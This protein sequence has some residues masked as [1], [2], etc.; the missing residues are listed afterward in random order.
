LQ[1]SKV[2]VVVVVVGGGVGGGGGGGGGV[3][4]HSSCVC[5]LSGQLDPNPSWKLVPPQV[6]NPLAAL[7]ML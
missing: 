1:E 5:S 3:I 2:V 7:A 6:S 4:S